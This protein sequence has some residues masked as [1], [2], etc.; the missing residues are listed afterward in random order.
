[1]SVKKAV[2]SSAGCRAKN[3]A[4]ELCRP[5]M[6][7]ASSAQRG[8]LT[9]GE[10]R[11]EKQTRE[12]LVCA[13]HVGPMKSPASRESYGVVVAVKGSVVASCPL[14]RRAS[15]SLALQAGLARRCAVCMFWGVPVAYHSTVRGGPTLERR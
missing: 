9:G 15:F 5:S 6:V 10:G 3:S 11:V 13:A 8:C 7:M 12:C 2:T 14:G 4:K 1:M